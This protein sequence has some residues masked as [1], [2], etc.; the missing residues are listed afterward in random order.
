MQQVAS[1]FALTRLCSKGL[2]ALSLKSITLMILFDTRKLRVREVK[3]LAWGTQPVTGSSAT[4]LPKTCVLYPVWLRTSEVVA[5]W[6]T[7]RWAWPGASAMK[8][9]ANAWKQASLRLGFL[10]G[11]KGQDPLSFFWGS[12]SPETPFQSSLPRASKLRDKGPIHWA[13]P[14]W[15][16]SG[17][18]AACGQSPSSSLAPSLDSTPGISFLCPWA[19]G[20]WGPHAVSLF[21]LNCPPRRHSFVCCLPPS[22]LCSKGSCGIQAPVN[23]QRGGSGPSHEPAIAS[24]L[25]HSVPFPPPRSP[26]EPLGLGPG[27]FHLHSAQERGSGQGEEGVA[28]E[29]CSLNCTLLS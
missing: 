17:Q 11:R 12:L 29:G 16:G 20:T 21:C 1:A 28:G 5:R 18:A 13:S 22:V 8:L 23:T 24:G 27:P 19:Q 14:S 6:P 3:S 26:E 2:G 10:L 25:T 15:S 7:R 4:W 9:S